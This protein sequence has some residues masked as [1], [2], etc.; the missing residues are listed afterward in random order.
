MERGFHWDP[1]M[2]TYRRRIKVIAQCKAEKKK[3]GP[4]YVR[5]LEGVLHH[6]QRYADYNRY[7]GVYRDHLSVTNTGLT[8]FQ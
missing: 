1:T 8:T 6:Y 4:K 3:L 7:E 2:K 5:E